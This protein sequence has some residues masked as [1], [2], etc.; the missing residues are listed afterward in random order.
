MSEEQMAVA[1]EDILMRTVADQTRPAAERIAAAEGLSV[2]VGGTNHAVWRIL[3]GALQDPAEDPQVRIAA[4]H[5]LGRRNRAA[6]PNQLCRSLE[7]DEDRRVRAEVVAILAVWGSVPE[8]QEPRLQRDLDALQS[9]MAPIPLM[10]LAASYGG[11][12]RVVAM[13]RQALH[14]SDPEIRDI[15]QRGLGMLGQMTDVLH[16]LH[17]GAPQVR[18]GAAE[19]LGRYSL[20]S[21]DDVAALELA[22]HDDDPRVQRAAKTSLRRLGIQSMPNPRASA[23]APTVQKAASV[24]LMDTAPDQWRPL[25]ERWSQQWLGVRDYAVELP[26]DVIEAG[27]LGYPGANEQELQELE[28]RLGRTLPRSYRTFLH[29]TNGWRRTS[30]FIEHVWPTTDVGY[31]RARN[32]DWIDVLL[33]HASPVTPEEHARYGDDQDTLTYRAEYLPETIQ[34]SPVGDAAVYLLNPAVVTPKGEWEAWFL[35]SWQPGAQRYPSF[36]DLMRAE[37]ASFVRWEKPQG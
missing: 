23:R 32:Q 29:L 19:T 14:H 5:A 18:A 17:D 4:A 28:Q 15:A 16:V 9:R 21:V 20:K 30:P 25:L 1:D 12:P 37:Y 31:F 24:S 27:W 33:E 13:L 26:D 6:A 36:W 7:G 3:C 10:N 2:P 11:D 34:V 22:L 35:A 8:A